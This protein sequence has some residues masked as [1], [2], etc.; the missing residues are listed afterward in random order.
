MITQEIYWQIMNEVR[1]YSAGVSLYEPP[2]K[3]FE[4]QH[5]MLQTQKFAD[6]DDYLLEVFKY[7]VIKK[8]R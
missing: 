3:G 5:K 8:G 4:E 2:P 7:V 1:F 6:R